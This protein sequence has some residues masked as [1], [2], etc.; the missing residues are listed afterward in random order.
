MCA[1]D[2]SHKQ[3]KYIIKLTSCKVEL[4]KFGEV[5]TGNADDNTEPSFHYL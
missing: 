4:R 2:I 3:I 1:Y 5:L